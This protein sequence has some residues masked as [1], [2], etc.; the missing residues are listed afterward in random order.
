MLSAPVHPIA[1]RREPTLLLVC[2]DLSAA[3][4]SWTAAYD[5]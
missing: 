3:F 2:Q 1:N 4:Y 5:F